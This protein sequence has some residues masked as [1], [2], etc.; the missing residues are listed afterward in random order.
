MGLKPIAANKILNKNVIL[1][2][3]EESYMLYEL[4]ARLCMAYKIL[5]YRS[6]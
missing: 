4:S 1:S 3:S 6:G 5:R 2:D